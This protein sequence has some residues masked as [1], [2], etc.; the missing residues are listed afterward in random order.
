[1]FYKLNWRLRR[2]GT[3]VIHPNHLNDYYIDYPFHMLLAVRRLRD[4]TI[5]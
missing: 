5:W 3:W 2:F 4:P 1:M